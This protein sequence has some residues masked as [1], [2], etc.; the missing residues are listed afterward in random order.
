MF[1]KIGSKFKSLIDN[2]HEFL[3]GLFG[4]FKF[5]LVDFLFLSFLFVDD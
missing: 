1:A 4:F 2:F 5:F 3:N